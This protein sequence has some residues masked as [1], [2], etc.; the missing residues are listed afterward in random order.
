MQSTE[1]DTIGG[2]KFC[3]RLSGDLLAFA[4]IVIIFLTG[5]VLLYFRLRFLIVGY[6]QESR[7][8]VSE[9]YM[10]GIFWDILSRFRVRDRTFSI[11]PGI[12]APLKHVILYAVPLGT[13]R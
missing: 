13:S 5:N 8:G 2:G 6:F 10:I 9:L 12:I 3:E 1:T 11:K 4:A 7:K